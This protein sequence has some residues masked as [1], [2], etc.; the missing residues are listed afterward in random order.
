MTVHPVNSATQFLDRSNPNLIIFGYKSSGKTYYGKLLAQKLQCIFIDTDQLIEEL[1]EKQFQQK[2]NCRQIY[3]TIKEERFRQL[4]H[5]IIDSLKETSNSIIAVGGGTILSANNYL[6]L[7]KLGT[8][9]FLEVEKKII[10]ER[11]LSKEIPSFLDAKNPDTSFEKMYAERLL[12]YANIP[13]FKLKTQ[14][15]SDS[16]ILDELISIRNLSSL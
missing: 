3:L 5:E 15:K 6:K 9:V 2:L 4:E 16:Q 11:I 1:Y 8:L 10:K 14:G 13:S 7:K 12:I